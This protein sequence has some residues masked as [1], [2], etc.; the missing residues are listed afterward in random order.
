TSGLVERRGWVAKN[1][2]RA[3]LRVLLRWTVRLDVIQHVSATYT[4]AKWISP[5]E[6]T[7]NGPDAVASFNSSDPVALVLGYPKYTPGYGSPGR[8]F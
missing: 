8:C 3:L 5:S 7:S 4:S 6:S 2:A 1:A